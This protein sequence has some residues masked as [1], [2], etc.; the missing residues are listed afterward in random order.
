[1]VISLPDALA[2]IVN[3]NAGHWLKACV[4]SMRRSNYGARVVIVDNAS[5]DD[6]IANL[7]TCSDSVQLIRN[8]DNVGFARANNQV[9]KKIN[10]AEFYV[11]LNPDCIVEE[12]TIGTVIA[13]MRMDQNI[14]LASCLIKNADGSIQKTCRRRFP[15]PATA[16]ARI[17]G[18]NVL[19]PDKFRDFD[20]GGD[21][22]KSGI[23]YVEAISGAF[24][25][26]RASTMGSV[27]Y[28]DEGYFM[29]CEDLD[30]CKRFWQAGF[31]VAFVA[32][33]F[34]THAK[35]ASGRSLRVNWYLH[36]GM[37]RFYKKF[38]VDDYPRV[39]FTLVY[40]GVFLSFLGRSTIILLR[41]P[42]SRA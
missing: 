38:Y 22:A 28:L 33:T 18:L 37:L 27:G 41:G 10:D 30:W 11:L 16:L 31:K 13:A 14:A 17:L 35:G 2:I 19:W 5:S 3:Y 4:E 40:I 26:V 6:S 15:T 9:L 1:M 8:A 39:L 12:D 32:G 29:H 36:Q 21:E 23:E 20:Y 42:H 34:V 25:V 24:M 7:D